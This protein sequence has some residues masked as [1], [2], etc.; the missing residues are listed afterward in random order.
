MK[1]QRLCRVGHVRVSFERRV[2][3]FVAFLL[4]TRRADTGASTTCL[5]AFL[6]VLVF[7]NSTF[8]NEEKIRI[9]DG[10]AEEKKAKKR[11]ENEE[12]KKE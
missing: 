10:N 3:S 5:P 12:K 2:A 6:L 4:P 8:R 7:L 1:F 9:S 11:K